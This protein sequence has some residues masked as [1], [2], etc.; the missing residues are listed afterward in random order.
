[1]MCE[2]FGIGIIQIVGIKHPC[3]ICLESV[4]V[5]S[6]RYT[7]CIQWVHVRYSSERLF[8]EYRE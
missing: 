6:I 8:E 3:I 2:S 1:M 4:G 5:K 7:Q